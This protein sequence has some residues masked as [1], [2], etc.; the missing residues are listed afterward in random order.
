MQA[1]EQSVRENCW[2][3]VTIQAIAATPIIGQNLLQSHL[4]A[5]VYLFPPTF[6]LP[7]FCGMTNVF[8][9]LCLRKITSQ[10]PI[11]S[12]HHNMQ[13]SFALSKICWL[14]SAFTVSWL[15]FFFYVVLKQKTCPYIR[16]FC[17]LQQ[18]PV[19]ILNHQKQVRHKMHKTCQ[20]SKSATQTQKDHNVLG[21]FYIW[22]FEIL[23]F[24]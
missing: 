15:H 5:H 10:T 17:L 16:C 7:S 3:L 12:E 1:L 4:V 23:N 13:A 19:S 21:V 2:P 22:I 8:C 14:Q 18:I 20:K 6:K 9:L 24:T 11:K